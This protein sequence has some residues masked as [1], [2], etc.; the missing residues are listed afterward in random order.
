MSNTSTI[1]VTKEEMAFLKEAKDLFSG[2]TKAKISWGA[3]LCALSMGGLAMK[4]TIGI[5]SRCPDCG[6]EVELRMSNPRDQATRK[7]RTGQKT[8]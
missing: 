8:V 4:T 1:S 5:L 7:P 2:F 3:Y 6:H